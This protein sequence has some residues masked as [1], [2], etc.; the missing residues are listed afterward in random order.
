MKPFLL[1]LTVMILIATATFAA[2][3][4]SG[5]EAGVGGTGVVPGH[6]D[7]DLAIAYGNG[8][9]HSIGATAGLGYGL[10]LWGDKDTTG[11]LDL[12][13]ILGYQAEPFSQT[14]HLMSGAATTG[15][16]HRL[17]GLARLGVT[18]GFFPERTLE[19]GLGLFGGWTEVIMHGTLANSRYG[20]SANYDA[21]KGVLASGA[22]LDI[23]VRLD[24]RLAIVGQVL[25]FLPYAD[26][27]VTGY[28]IAS[29]GLS[30]RLF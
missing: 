22:I 3:S 23:G 26:I 19:V 27:A 21:A 14:D 16:A 4:S 24:E 11:Q 12:G 10:P 1:S 15:A 18:V 2:D 30:V 8:G 20:V 28:I 7:L 25:G 17:E 29:L 9:L 13:L 5:Q 6:L